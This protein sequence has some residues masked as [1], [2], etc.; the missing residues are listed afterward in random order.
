MYTAEA[1]NFHMNYRMKC[2]EETKKQAVEIERL[3]AEAERLREALEGFLS[4]RTDAP[5]FSAS[6]T[7]WCLK[8][9]K[10]LAATRKGDSN[11]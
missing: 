2:D 5:S 1:E 11:G 3:R 10:A 8:G 7:V 4:L 6:F 9:E